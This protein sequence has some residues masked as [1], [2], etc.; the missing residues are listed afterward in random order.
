MAK[1]QH[2]RWPTRALWSAEESDELAAE[3]TKHL[4]HAT[5]RIE[6]AI[7]H[8]RSNPDASELMLAYALRDVSDGKANQEQIRRILAEARNGKEAPRDDEAE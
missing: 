1:P 7:A 2:Q 4:D 6:K 5:A 8:L 3:T